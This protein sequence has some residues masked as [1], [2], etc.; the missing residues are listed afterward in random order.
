MTRQSNRRLLLLNIFQ[1]IG[2]EYPLN[3]ELKPILDRVPLGRQQLR[4]R[5]HHI[6]A[7]YYFLSRL[8]RFV[9]GL[10]PLS[11]I[12]NFSGLSRYRLWMSGPTAP[13]ITAFHRRVQREEA[14]VSTELLECVMWF[15]G[16]I[17]RF[18]VTWKVS[19]SYF[20]AFQVIWAFLHG[21]DRRNLKT[22]I[23]PLLADPLN[24]TI[25]LPLQSIQTSFPILHHKIDEYQYG[26]SRSTQSMRNSLSITTIHAP[27]FF[28][29]GSLDV[30]IPVAGS[31]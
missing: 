19:S 8:V 12:R 21:L 15:S 9:L 4:I 25:Q 20:L 5:S 23:I 27:E 22:R 28:H 2:D 11:S 13:Q 24:Y 16:W 17:E 1:L 7:N 14:V 3:Q 31:L 18:L 6:N 10:F 29:L 30:Q 26:S